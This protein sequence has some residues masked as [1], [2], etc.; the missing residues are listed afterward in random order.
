VVCG[1]P[2]G[3]DIGNII[4]Q[5]IYEVEE[6]DTHFTTKDLDIKEWGENPIEDSFSSQEAGSACIHVPGRYLND[7]RIPNQKQACLKIPRVIK[8][9]CKS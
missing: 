6:F 9:P 4:P 7:L 3:E 2:A 5:L 1:Q 8:V